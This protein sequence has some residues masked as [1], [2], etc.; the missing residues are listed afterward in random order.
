M[1]NNI[2]LCSQHTCPAID[3]CTRY[4]SHHVAGRDTSYFRP[5]FDGKKVPPCRYLQ[6]W[7]DESR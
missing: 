7:K 1:K 2:P 6:E 3:A 5:V 4:L